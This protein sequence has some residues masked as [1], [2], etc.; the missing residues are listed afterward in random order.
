M[1]AGGILVSL[2]DRDRRN[3]GA[4]EAWQPGVEASEMQARVRFRKLS[5]PP[6]A[7][8]GLDRVQYR[9]QRRANDVLFSP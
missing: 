2:V 8:L 7:V 3:P 6:N 4:E 1:P 9:D 5:Y